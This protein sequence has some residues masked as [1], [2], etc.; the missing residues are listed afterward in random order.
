MMT[1]RFP[2]RPIHRLLPIGVSALL[3]APLWARLSAPL[4]ARL[5]ALLW[6]LLSAPLWA[7]PS[8]VTVPANAETSTGNSS[9]LFPFASTVPSERHQWAFDPAVLGFTEPVLITGIAIR[10]N[11]SA[12]GLAEFC[13]PA[14]ELALASGSFAVPMLSSTNLDSNLAGG[15]KVVRPSMPFKGG[16][17]LPPS[18]APFVSKWVPIPFVDAFE[19]DPTTALSLV[20][21]VKV[22]AK[23]QAWSQS[24]DGATIASTLGRT[25]A[26]TIGCTANF[27]SSLSSFV[28]VIRFDYHPSAPQWQ[29]N[30]AAAHL[31]LDGSDNTPFQPIRVK[32][33]VGD[34]VTFN[35]KST[36]VS[37]AFLLWISVAPAASGLGAGLQTAGGQFINV[38][39]SAPSILLPGVTGPTGVDSSSVAPL[40][41]VLAPVTVQLFV[42]DP[43]HPD[44]YRLS[45][46]C[47]LEVLAA[48]CG[49]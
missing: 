10:A 28:P 13:F 9:T 41:H 26:S 32:K 17:V 40:T 11:S 44:G 24:M 25:F 30:S 16:P 12:G 47:E 18:M 36:S 38:D 34:N 6:V 49:P 8:Y 4:W 1:A 5:S 42:E 20:V 23:T 35:L 21:D 2:T 22:C 29:T 39:L 31:D 14:V 15:G 45:A 3:S 46:A 19:F 27:G 43:T 48:G 33:S 37:R 7:Q